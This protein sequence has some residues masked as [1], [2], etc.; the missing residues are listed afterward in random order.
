LK[1]G[2][3]LLKVGILL[4]GVGNAKKLDYFVFF[5]MIVIDSKGGTTE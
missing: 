3:L 2:I 5:V 4:L 1:V